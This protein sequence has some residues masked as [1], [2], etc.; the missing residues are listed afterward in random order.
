MCNV[1]NSNEVIL[2]VYWLLILE[3]LAFTYFVTFERVAFLLFVKV[4]LNV[5][6]QNDN[7]LC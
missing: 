7:N 1:K 5:K 4:V 6:T 2:H 3:P